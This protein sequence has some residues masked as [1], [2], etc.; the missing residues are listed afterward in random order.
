VREMLG[1]W[2]TL[3]IVISDLADAPS[4]EEGADNIDAALEH[5]DR[6]HRISL[7]SVPSS[8]FERF[9]TAMLEPFPEL[10]SLALCSSD[11]SALV[12][13]DTFLGGSA[14]RLHTL[15]FNNIA[16]P[17]L[18]MLLTPLLDLVHL[19]VW[20]IPDSSYISPDA[21]VACIS[22]M[23]RLQSLHL[24]FSSP[25]SRPD[26]TGRRHPPARTVLPALFRF[27]YKG[28]S[29]YLENFVAQI[30]A[31][32]LRVVRITFFNQI[33]FDISQVSRFMEHTKNLK[34]F[35]HADIVFSSHSVEVKLYL[36]SGTIDRTIL[37][38][39]I[40]CG[41]SDWQLSA[42]AQICGPSSPC[43]STLERLDIREDQHSPPHWQDDIENSQWVELLHPFSTIKSLYISKG[44]APRVTL[45]LAEPAGESITELLLPVLQNLFLE[46]PP[47]MGRF[48]DALAELVAARQLSGNPLVIHR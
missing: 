26:S 32:L 34:A 38:M 25:L 7:W 29:E 24:G 37:S 10:T 13:P 42:L 41:V 33:I 15:Y 30:N 4:L 22:T 47:S 43:L 36:R 40:S 18:G 23:T 39:G 1:I 27:E 28:V 35:N 19:Y 11:E 2:P 5:H 14:P 3:P 31:P 20:D 17:A 44:L 8:L 12:L 16:F 46:G 9:T 6:V 48:Q 21:I 45:P